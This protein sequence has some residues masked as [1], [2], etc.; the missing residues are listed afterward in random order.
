MAR[1][2]HITHHDNLPSLIAHGNLLCDKRRADLK[3][4]SV[5]IAHE[6]IKARRAVTAVTRPHMAYST[7]TSRFILRLALQCSMR[8]KGAGL[9]AT[10]ADR[11]ASFT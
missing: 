10:L 3:L 11:L 7:T 5:S 4:A 8:S 1:I 2:Y 6:N 9:T